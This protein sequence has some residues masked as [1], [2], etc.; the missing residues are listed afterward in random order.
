VPLG[1]AL[2]SFAILLLWRKMKTRK[3]NKLVRDESQL[4][5]N[6]TESYADIKAQKYKMYGA[7]E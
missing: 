4:L 2:L 7:L 6:P 1:A 5:I 3:R